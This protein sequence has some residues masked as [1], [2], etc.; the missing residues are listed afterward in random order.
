MASGAPNCMCWGIGTEY[1]SEYNT[2][3][4]ML[5]NAYKKGTLTYK[6]IMG[7]YNNVSYYDFL[8]DFANSNYKNSGYSPDNIDYSMEPE[9]LKILLDKNN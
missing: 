2:W 5:I 3:M 1:V 4:T 7:G 8:R 9:A 6:Q